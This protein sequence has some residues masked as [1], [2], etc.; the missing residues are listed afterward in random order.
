[1]LSQENE[2]DECPIQHLLYL[3][4]GWFNFHAAPFIAVLAQLGIELHQF[5]KGNRRGGL[6]L[7]DRYEYNA[8]QRLVWYS[9]IGNGEQYNQCV[10]NVCLVELVQLRRQKT[11]ENTAYFIICCVKIISPKIYFDL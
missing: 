2:D 1:V 4:D 9:H 3:N 11:F 5:N 6:L 8:L 10:E 7:E